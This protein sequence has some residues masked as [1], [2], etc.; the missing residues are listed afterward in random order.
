MVGL[1]G[2]DRRQGARAACESLPPTTKA[3][4]EVVA[5][6]VWLALCV[7]DFAAAEEIL[8]RDQ[9]KERRRRKNRATRAS[10]RLLAIRRDCS[11][12]LSDTPNGRVANSHVNEITLRTNISRLADTVPLL[13]KPP[14]LCRTGECL[15]KRNPCAVRHKTGY[16]IALTG[17]IV[18]LDDKGRPSF[19]LLHGF[20]MGLVRP[21]IV[22]YAFDLLRLNGQD[23]RSWP[24]EERKTK[25][26]ALL[27]RPPAEILCSASFTQNIVE[28]LSKVR[29]FS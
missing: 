15:E 2:E 7:R 6:R 29:E 21:P 19:Q 5:N 22:F 27:K 26:A 13:A 4:P 24:F 9:N 25:L 18:A 17:E 20:D 3:E 8:K 1:C 14:L 12:V 10:V 16:G 28:L 11:K 23:L